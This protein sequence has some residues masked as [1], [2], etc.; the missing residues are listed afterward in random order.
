MGGIT[1]APGTPIALYLV[2]LGMEKKEFVRSIA[3][4]FLVVKGVQLVTLIWYGLLVW[5]LALVSLGLAATGLAG[6]ALGL[7]LQ[8]RLD[9]R[10]FSRAVLIFLAALGV[11]LLVR[12]L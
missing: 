9:Q 10:S 4:T 12:T 6:F 3:F 1:N 2:A 5:S 11:W 7:K 8:D